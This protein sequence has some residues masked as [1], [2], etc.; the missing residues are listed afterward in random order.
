MSW[1]KCISKLT[2][3]ADYLKW[4]EDEATRCLEECRKANEA[5]A[6]LQGNAVELRY[7][8]AHKK[9]TTNG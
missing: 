9:P 7:G 2:E 8:L 3:A 1:D 4:A 6:R 5:I